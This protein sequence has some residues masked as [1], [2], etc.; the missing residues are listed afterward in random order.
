MNHS[1]EYQAYPDEKALDPEK[2]NGGIDSKVSLAGARGEVVNASGHKDQLQRHY[3]LL[4]TCGLALTID[5]AWVALGGSI[6][7]SICK[8]FRW[9][10]YTSSLL[11]NIILDNGGPPGIL[12]EFLVACFYYAFIAASIAEV[13]H[14]LISCSSTFVYL[15]LAPLVG[16]CYTDSWRC[17]S[18]GFCHSRSSSWPSHWLLHGLL[19][20]LRL[21][22]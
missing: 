1:D 4:A 15:L 8:L 7:V 5:N 11:R 13:L 3:G 2:T 10:T 6:A 9:R 14:Y 18:L 12:Y 17:L 16:I 22:L 21:D 19:E 20:L